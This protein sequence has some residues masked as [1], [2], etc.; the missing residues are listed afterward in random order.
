MFLLKV[1]FVN[2]KQEKCR[3]VLDQHAMEEHHGTDAR[4]IRR[5]VVDS[6]LPDVRQ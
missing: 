6:L 2:D 1:E 5:K 4:R 3:V